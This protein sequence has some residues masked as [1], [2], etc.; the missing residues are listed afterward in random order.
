MTKFLDLGSLI[1]AAITLVLFVVA[2]FTKGFTH[3]L[4]LE[5]GVFL[6]SVKI[7]MMQ[8]RN[9]VAASNMEKKLDSLL[10]SLGGLGGKRAPSLPHEKSAAE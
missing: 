6:I 7:I 3:D 5:A 4:F 2:L 9:A 8:H 1:V 10:A